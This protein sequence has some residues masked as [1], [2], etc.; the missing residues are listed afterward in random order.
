M[1]GN[2]KKILIADDNSLNRFATKSMLEKNGFLVECVQNGKEVITAFTCSDEGEFSAIL[3]DT[4]MPIY[5]GIN[6]TGII[7]GS[8]HSDAESIPI[9]AVTVIDSEHERKSAAAAG[10]NDYLVK[11]F[12]AEALM[13][14]LAKYIK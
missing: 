13:S 9:I 4:T 3:M 5:D 11:P 8:S 1:D 14:M 12:S 2:K 10:M 6:A 7:R